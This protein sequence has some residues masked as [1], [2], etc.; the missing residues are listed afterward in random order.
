MDDAVGEIWNVTE[1]GDVPKGFFA[2]LFLRKDLGEM[3]I[4]A[5]I[6][7]LVAALAIILFAWL[8]G[9]LYAKLCDTLRTFVVTAVSKT[10][11][12][13]IDMGKQ[14]LLSVPRHV[15]FI[16]DG[17]RR[18][19]RRRQLRTAEGHKMGYQALKNLLEFC[20][21]FGVRTVSVYAF[22]IE[23]FKRSAEVCLLCARYVRH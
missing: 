13:R 18:W 11:K 9:L 17:N 12:E 20:E 23:N 4:V 8:A 2:D 16:M 22:S 6:F 5:L 1:S 10:F 21:A 7:L 14:P 19:A 15:A 3:V